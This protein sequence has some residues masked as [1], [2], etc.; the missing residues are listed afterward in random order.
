GIETDSTI[1][2]SRY[3]SRSIPRTRRRKDERNCLRNF[4][5]SIRRDLSGLCFELPFRFEP[6]LDIVALCPSSGK[7]QFVCSSR[8]VIS[9]YY[10]VIRSNERD[11]F[12]LSLCL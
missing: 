10:T 8:N 9:S 5:P 6:V 7:E 11:G 4:G 1:P 12:C 3:G 2:E